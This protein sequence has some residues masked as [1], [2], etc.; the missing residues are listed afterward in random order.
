[1]AKTRSARSLASALIVLGTSAVLAGGPR[2]M[3]PQWAP[4]APSYRKKGAANPVVVIAE[5]SDFQCPAC[6]A[7]VPHLKSILELFPDKVGVVFKHKAWDFHPHAR[8]AAVAAECAGKSG[9]FWEY[10]DKLFAAQPAWSVLESAGAAAAYF[11]TTAAGLGVE[12]AAFTAC[13]ADPAV[14]ALVQ[15][16]IKEGEEKWVNSTPTFVIGGRRFVGSN[17]LRT[18]GLNRIEDL[19]KKNKS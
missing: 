18:L 15:A 10:H 3:T 9:K 6:G 1:M 12:R 7:A 11:E 4:D 14:L 8:A 19:I 5:F 13:T 2:L 16:D 17:Q